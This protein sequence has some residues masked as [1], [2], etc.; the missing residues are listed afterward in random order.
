MKIFLGMPLHSVHG[1]T[2]LALHAFEQ[3]SRLSVRAQVMADSSLVNCF[4]S[5]WCAALNYGAE[6]FAMQHGDVEPQPGWLDVLLAEGARQQADCIAAVVPLKDNRGVTSTAIDDPDNPWLPLRRLTMTEIWNGSLPA[7][8]GS[9]DLRTRNALLVNT[10][11]MLVRMAALP[12]DFV[13][14]Q[15]ARRVRLLNDG[16]WASQFQPEDWIMSRTLH[17]LGRRVFATRAVPLTHRGDF[18]YAND[19]PWGEVIDRQS[20]VN[21]ADANLPHV[22]TA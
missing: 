9:A 20:E 21:H 19:R 17:R 8:F 4:T 18:G 3:P 13:F 5:L 16:L 7:T 10:G 2:P 14:E 22:V 1:A 11:C 15:V 12:D 6:L